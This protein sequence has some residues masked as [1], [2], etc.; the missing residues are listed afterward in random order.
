M[1]RSVGTVRPDGTISDGGWTPTPVSNYIKESSPDGNYVQ[2]TDGE[3][4][5]VTMGT[6]SMPSNNRVNKITIYTYSSTCGYL[7]TIGAR[8]RIG[9]GTER[10]STFW[11]GHTM[12]MGISG[13]IIGILI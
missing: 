9:S 7:Y 6:F 13:C 1:G 10:I 12:L 3:A 2:G 8:Y 11:V 5:E 4:F